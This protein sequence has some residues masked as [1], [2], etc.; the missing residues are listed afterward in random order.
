[1]NKSRTR[2]A[3]SRPNGK[4]IFTKSIFGIPH[5]ATIVVLLLATTALGSGIIYFGKR[6]EFWTDVP[7][8]RRKGVHEPIV[9]HQEDVAPL[10]PDVLGWL[11]EH[12]QRIELRR[13]AGESLWGETLEFLPDGRIVSY[14]LRPIEKV[15]AKNLKTLTYY[16][17]FHPNDNRMAWYYN[18]DG[19]PLLIKYVKSLNRNH[20][21]TTGV[22][23]SS[24]NRNNEGVNYEYAWERPRSQFI[25]EKFNYSAFWGTQSHFGGV[26]RIDQRQWRIS[27]PT[28]VSNDVYK[29]Y[30]T[31]LRLPEGSKVTE[32]KP[33]ANIRIDPRNHPIVTFDGMIENGDYPPMEVTYIISPEQARKAGRAK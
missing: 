33:A 14:D 6:W 22:V 25:W 13:Q 23:G 32:T 8:A 20:V 27:F 9:Y 21:P 15:F 10:P 5:F 17:T 31:E 30:C 26:Q 19:S 11:R 4:K 3:S 2:W 29:R 16:S 24:P 12:N 18:E 28:G 7:V 1:M